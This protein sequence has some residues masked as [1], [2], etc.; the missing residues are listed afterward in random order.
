MD[1]AKAE[2]NYSV[3]ANKGTLWMPGATDGPPSAL[4]VPN[5]LA[6]H[7]ALVDLLRTP[8]PAITPHE[9]LAIVEEFIQNSGHPLGQQ[10]ECIQ[11][12]CLV[13]CQTGNNGKSR[14]FLDTVPVTIDDDKFD[15]WVGTKLDITLGPRPSG[16][17]PITMVAAAG[18]QAIAYL[19][20]SKMLAT[21]IG[22]N[23]MQFS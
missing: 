1:V 17:T 6:I 15:Q 21:T 19:A 11:C 8:G 20:M 13:A 16:A 18:T 23:M 7:N 2:A 22:A 9:V 14:V 5:L 4:T 3:E 10:W 12:W